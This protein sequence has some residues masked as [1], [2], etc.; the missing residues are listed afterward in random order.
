MLSEVT[1]LALLSVSNAFSGLMD[2]EGEWT[3]KGEKFAAIVLIAL[4]LFSA[5]IM[6]EPFR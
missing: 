5:W 2:K 4:F 3:K 6:G 1:K